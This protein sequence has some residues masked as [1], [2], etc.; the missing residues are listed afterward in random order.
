MLVDAM[1]EERFH[2]SSRERAGGSATITG[3]GVGVGYSVSG[4]PGPVCRR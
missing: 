4:F 2:G 1:V 3:G